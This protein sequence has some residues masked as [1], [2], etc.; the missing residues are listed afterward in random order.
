MSVARAQK[1]IS[2]MEYTRWL[3]YFQLDP[4][5][6]GRAD[7]RNA[8]TSFIM[9]QSIPEKRKKKLKLDDFM[10]KSKY[11]QEANKQSRDDMWNQVVSYS[12]A[13]DKVKGK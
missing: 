12:A 1:E 8:V 2:S 4:F 6:E 3:A 5:G 7:L 11:E 13:F 9:Y 10:F